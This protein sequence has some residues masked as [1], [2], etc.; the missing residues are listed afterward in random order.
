M[1]EDKSYRD[2]LTQILTRGLV[3]QHS[4]A[5]GGQFYVVGLDMAQLPGKYDD[6]D[7]AEELLTKLRLDA[8]VAL[9]GDPV[10]WRVKDFAD[11]WILCHTEKQALLEAESAGNLV[12]AL[13]VI[14]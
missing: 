4:S 3:N 7:E 9:Q 14:S 1:A 8:I 2:Q 12:Q 5:H 11:G 13:G 6:R 10:A